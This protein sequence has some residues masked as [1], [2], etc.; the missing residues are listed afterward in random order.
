ML[1]SL[2]F[3]ISIANASNSTG[4]AHEIRMGSPFVHAV[5][6]SPRLA[7]P[8]PD[9]GW[10]DA[11]L[12]ANADYPPCV[13]PHAGINDAAMAQFL[14]HANDHESNTLIVIKNGC[15]VVERHYGDPVDKAYSVQ[16]VTKS[17]ASLAIGTLYDRH[18][19]ENLDTPLSKVL[20]GLASD[21][22]K[23]T[24][25]FRN[26]LTHT[27]GYGDWDTLVK[28]DGGVLA[29]IFNTP[30]KTAP[31]TAFSYSSMAVYLLGPAISQ[32]AN[33]PADQYIQANIFDPLNIHSAYWPKNKDGSL[34]VDTG[35]GLFMDTRDMIKLGDMML[36]S[37]RLNG[38]VLV[39][40]AWIQQS[41]SSSQN[42]FRDYGLLWWLYYRNGSSY[43]GFSAVGYQ[44]QYVTVYPKYGLIV[45][46]THEVEDT[47]DSNHVQKVFW[48]SFPEEVAGLAAAS[49][50]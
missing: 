33:Q 35:G 2:I 39:S 7:P 5:R 27:S 41:L 50:S 6:P 16:S 25:T 34:D 20:T 43:D 9:A 38:R 14:Q 49:G 29:E 8:P 4:A 36:H 17:V 15:T 11:G 13:N 31:G 28:G 1:I 30:L 47:D 32:L 22:V 18:V 24:I 12:P 44:G 19:L 46:R 42:L 10:I 40:Q 23:S 48:E 26:I 3:S 45:I 21:S 37:G